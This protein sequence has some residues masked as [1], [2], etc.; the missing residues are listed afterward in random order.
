MNTNANI[1]KPV[2]DRMFEIIMRTNGQSR[3]INDNYNLCKLKLTKFHIEN[4]DWEY[5]VI[6]S[7]Y[8]EVFAKLAE[9]FT[10]KAI[11]DML[12]HVFYYNLTV[13]PESHEDG[14]WDW[15]VGRSEDDLIAIAHIMDSIDLKWHHWLERQHEAMDTNF[16]NVV[17]PTADMLVERKAAGDHMAQGIAAMFSAK[18]G[19]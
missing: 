18:E 6:R 8:P 17:P 11:D 16:D 13:S 14:L 1:T 4:N 19:Y 9:G 3:R 5:K 15:L 10:A 7:V 12:R 2:S